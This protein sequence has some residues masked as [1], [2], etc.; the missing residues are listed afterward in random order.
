MEPNCSSKQNK[1]PLKTLNSTL[2][3]LQQ[4]DDKPNVNLHHHHYHHHHV[5]AR[6]HHHHIS[7]NKGLAVASIPSTHKITPLPKLSILNDGVLTSVAH[8]PRHHLGYGYYGSTLKAS[9]YPISFNRDSGSTRGFTSTPDALPLFAGRENCTYTVKIP[10]IYLEDFVREEVT[11]RKAIWGTDIYTDDSDVL[12]ACI[13]AG[14]FRGAWPEDVDVSLLGLELKNDENNDPIPPDEIQENQLL[15]N[16]SE[17]GPSHIPPGCDCHVTILILPLL[18]HYASSTRFGIKSREW[19]M[20]RG[21]WKGKHDG[22]SFMIKSVRFVSGVNGEEGKS[23]R[24][25]CKILK[26]KLKEKE[27]N[28]TKHHWMNCQ[29][30]EKDGSSQ[31]DFEKDIT[32]MGDFVGLR[33]LGM[34]GWWK[35]YSNFSSCREEKITCKAQPLKDCGA[36]SRIAVCSERRSSTHPYVGEPPGAEIFPSL[37]THDTLTNLQRSEIISQITETMKINA[38]YNGP[39]VFAE[40]TDE[41]PPPKLVL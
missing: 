13:H 35:R 31:G 14:W 6:H 26:R 2:S 29:R 28:S 18:D 34:G 8:L 24:N 17:K 27:T 11:S 25:R 20:E 10:R 30:I 9:S 15:E 41:T 33:G 12:A 38:N 37:S 4:T 23:G 32:K 5:A 36:K 16:P 3:F 40:L 1:I 19:G 39:R 7:G 21:G 22:L